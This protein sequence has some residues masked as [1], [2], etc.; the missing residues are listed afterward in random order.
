MPKRKPLNNS[1]RHNRAG[2]AMATLQADATTQPAGQPCL[3][4]TSGNLNSR[5]TSSRLAVVELVAG[6]FHS[7]RRA[8][9]SASALNAQPHPRVLH[10][11][12]L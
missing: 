2:W 6:G 4:S 8:L 3:R 10:R 12:T 9:A 5:R 11:M 7:S 1:S